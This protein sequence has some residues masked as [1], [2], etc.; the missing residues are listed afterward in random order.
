MI[1][2][3]HRVIEWFRQA[4]QNYGKNCFYSMDLQ[5][6]ILEK[7]AGKLQELGLGGMD[8]K[9]R[10]K[11]ANNGKTDGFLATSKDFALM[12]NERPS[13]AIR[14][15]IN[16]QL[17]VCECECMIK[18][19]FFNSLCDLVGEDVFDIVFANLRIATGGG[20][21][22]AFIDQQRIKI[23]E[24]DC[25]AGDW[26]FVAHTTESALQFRELAEKK[27]TGG[28]ASGWNVICVSGGGALQNTYLGFGLSGGNAAPK[29][30]Q[31]IKSAMIQECG[32]DPNSRG[33]DLYL[34]FRR[35]LNA[36]RFLQWVR[37]ELQII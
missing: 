2:L 26:T 8:F 28:S 23:S 5:K 22:D 15:F 30:L 12:A 6:I 32:G 19:V 34:H 7:N 13:V 25:N 33:W 24:S 37:N 3:P 20:V 4:E 18:A 1:Q 36:N 10:I 9:A 35:R 27:K 31:Q 11:L 29:T 16:G 21:E 14:A 17:T